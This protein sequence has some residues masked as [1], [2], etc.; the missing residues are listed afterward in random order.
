MVGIYDGT[1]IS[2]ERRKII[3]Q[4][5][6]REGVSK[7]IFIESICD[8]PAV[9]EANIRETKL[10]SPDYPGQSP[11]EIMAQVLA[12][13][14][15]Y[16]KAYETIP[17]TSNAPHPYIKIFEG[18]RKIITHKIQGYLAGRIIFFLMN[19]R[20]SARPVWLA[21]CGETEYDLEDR[22]G[23]D[24]ELTPAGD[25]FAHKLAAWV[26]EHIMKEENQELTVWTSTLKRSFRTA[27]YIPHP[28]VQLRGLDDLERGMC[29][30]MTMNDFAQKMPEEFAA[31]AADKL[32]YRWPR[33]ESY[34]DVIQRLEPVIFEL[35]RSRNPLLIVSH[36]TPLRFLHAYLMGMGPEEAVVLKIPRN[37]VFEILPTAYNCVVRS[38][39]LM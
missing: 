30:G 21:T 35:E 24:A 16:A 26:D 15:G 13:V 10:T 6:T 17:E 18:G 36:P 25:N 1:N 2:A 11:K 8:D 33:G 29:D 3:A 39:T 7:I 20:I 19:L 31:R 14:E 23:G 38:H 37:T 27:Q 4:R 28:K 34:E 9:I 5:C 22:L 12:K 32:P